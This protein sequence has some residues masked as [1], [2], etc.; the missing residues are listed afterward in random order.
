MPTESALQDA[1]CGPFV[2]DVIS[3]SEARSIVRG[4][5]ELK[6]LIRQG[7]L[8]FEYAREILDEWFAKM[9]AHHSAHNQRIARDVLTRIKLE[10]FTDFSN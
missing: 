4:A 2:P 10:V 1:I 7:H 5:L 9:F 3:S 6:K 8:S